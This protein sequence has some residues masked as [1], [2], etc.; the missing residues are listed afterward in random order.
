LKKE[1]EEGEGGL[2]TGNESE[3]KNITDFAL[4][5]KSKPGEPFWQSPWYLFH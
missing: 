1:L 4:W 2:T 5:K 3:K